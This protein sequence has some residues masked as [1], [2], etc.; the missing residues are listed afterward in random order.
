[1]SHYTY[2]GERCNDTAGTAVLI[3]REFHCSPQL[4][5]P[6]HESPL[7]AANLLDRETSPYLLQHQDN[8]VHW[9]P[10]GSEAFARARTENKPVLL[11]VGYAACHW[12]HVMAH[13]SFENSETAALMN[14]LFI[15]VKVDREERPDID[16]I[17]Q[18][19]LSLLGQQGGWPLTMFLTPDGKPFWGGTYFPPESRYGRPGFPD[20][21][22]G[23]A[24]TWEKEQGK[25]TRNVDAIGNALEQM[26][27]NRRAGDL[28]TGILDQVAE[29][30][31]Q[32]IDP[33]N[34]GIGNAPKFPQVPILSL[35]WRA[36]KRTGRAPYREAVVKSLIHMCQGGIYDHLGGGFSR[37]SVDERWLAPH[38]EKMLYDNAQL[39][40]LLTLVWQE[41]RTPLFEMR[42]RE[43]VGWL[44]REMIADGGGF[45]A[46]L[47]ADSEG[48]EGRFYVWTASEID[49]VLGPDALTF[50]SIYDV[51]SIG[52]WEGV[53][54]LNRL[55]SLE[56]FD[57]ATEAILSDCRKRLLAE[58]GKRVRPGWDDKVL[59]DWNGLMIASLTRAGMV[60]AEPGWIDRARQAFDFIA[61]S[62]VQNDRLLHSW[63]VG[64]ARHRAMLDDLALMA[65]AGLALHE[66]TGDEQPLRLARSWVATLD[67][68]F[69]DPVSGGYFFTA[70]DADDLFIR[71]KS[72]NDSAIPNGN[73][74]MVGVLSDLYLLTGEDHYLS[75]ADALVTAFSG[76]VARNFFPLPT[77][78]NAVERRINGLH[79]IIIG[80]EVADNLTL[81]VLE[82]S[83]PDRLLTRLAAGTHLPSS[84]PA[85]GK[86]MVDGKP[87]AYVCKGMTCS[88]PVTEP[89]ALGAVLRGQ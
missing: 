24:Q 64:E 67:Q 50:K 78:F 49:R 8:P 76:E 27:E 12:C 16:Q 15:P 48:E 65:L 5:F 14:D 38:F 3:L 33:I 70:D 88:V 40:E 42:I 28:D 79:I 83:L 20:V 31:V 54:I 71:T 53:T 1:M 13:E 62:M 80:D 63:R 46:S 18:S 30:L 66:A 68:H 56:R 10:W 29:R 11:S 57:E 55:N 35:L 47:D 81:T 6:A 4:L 7:M 41:T 2:R 60:F 23:I 17:Y 39:I 74:V 25:V 34:G 75:R 32:E 87:T 77:Y 22:K 44:E 19:A 85:S 86:G 72:A 73:G 89:A 61:S 51:S 45:A 36:W 26:A 69:W 58:R 59:A 52:N 21:L 84:H 82:H 43:T 37:Y 9:M